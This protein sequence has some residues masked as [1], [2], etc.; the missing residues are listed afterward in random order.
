MVV[1]RGLPA[2][3]TDGV[4]IETNIVHPTCVVVARGRACS[5]VG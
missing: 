5:A 3:S 2:Q 1:G 4:Q